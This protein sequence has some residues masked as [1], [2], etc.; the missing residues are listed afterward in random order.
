MLKALFALFI[1]FIEKKFGPVFFY[2]EFRFS[3]LIFSSVT[4]KTDVFFEL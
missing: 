3:G 1:Y 2:F 4:V